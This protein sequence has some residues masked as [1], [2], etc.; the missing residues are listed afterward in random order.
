M[1]PQISLEETTPL[2]KQRNCE[3]V[4][5]S[6]T[7][8]RKK[9]R[10]RGESLLSPLWQNDF[11]RPGESSERGNFTVAFVRTYIVCMYSLVSLFLPLSGSE[12]MHACACIAYTQ[13]S[14]ISLRGREYENTYTPC[15]VRVRI[16]LALLIPNA[17]F[18]DKCKWREAATFL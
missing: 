17:N 18:N 7:S 9:E 2:H 13:R 16:L 15:I 6:I 14:T 4:R 11:T 10:D 12:C 5:A 1:R 8:G 3:G